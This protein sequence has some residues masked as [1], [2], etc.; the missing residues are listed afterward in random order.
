M[1]NTKGLENHKG[2]WRY[3]F[4]VK[5]N[6]YVV[7]TGLEATQANAAAA[8]RAMTEHRKRL[9]LGETE[10]EAVMFTEAVFQFNDWKE[11][12]HRDKPE[13]ARRI[14]ISL[15]NWAKRCGALRMDELTIAHVQD[16]MTWRRKTQKVAEVTLRKDVFALR[17]LVRFA[18]QRGW[19]TEDPTEEIAVPSDKDSRNEVVLTPAEE[20]AYLAACEPDMYDLA[21]LMLRNGLRPSEVLALKTN[22]HGRNLRILEGKSRAAKRTLYLGDEA[23]STLLSRKSVDRV[24]LWPNPHGRG[25]L[26]YKQILRAHY[27]ALKLSGLSFDIYSLRHTFATRF[28]DKTKDLVALAAVLGHG[29]LRTVYRYV[30]DG[31]RRAMEAMREFAG[32]T[33]GPLEATKAAPKLPESARNDMTETGRT[34]G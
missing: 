32:A 11:G 3:R 9:L 13:T 4:Q 14:N 33:I 10:T 26:P 20:Q 21:I 29:D 19:M 23:L 17:Q 30:N 31:D 24:W 16:F 15:R 2:R 25:P 7:S 27:R 28:Y 8:R 5:G 1:A 12:E 18:K 22:V 6:R 34:N